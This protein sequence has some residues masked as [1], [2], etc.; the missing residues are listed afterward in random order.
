MIKKYLTLSLIAAVGMFTG[1]GGGG[2]SS[3]NSSSNEQNV[4]DINGKVV[5]GYVKNAKVCIDLNN[6][7]QCDKNE[8]P[9]TSDAN[10]SYSFKN[11]ANKNYTL[12]STGGIDTQNN[13]PSITMYSNTK[14][15]NITPLTSLAVKE[16]EDKVAEY[17]NINKNQISADPMKNN[18]IKNIVTNIVNE[19][20]TTGK[21]ELNT[22]KKSATDIT[23]FNNTTDANT[24]NISDINN[25]TETNTT[26]NNSSANATQ[27]P[28]DT[29]LP[30]QI[31]GNLTPPKIGE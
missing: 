22:P 23:D 19:V 2:G 3:D 27:T 17:F 13:T 15:K 4:T 26:D 31:S 7:F 9:T 8:P 5:D 25:T 12:I 1:C 29:N 16:G 10:G 11:I 24:T 28:G 14:Y 20:K 21:Y 6:N 18:E 30:P